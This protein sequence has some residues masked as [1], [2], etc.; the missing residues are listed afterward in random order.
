MLNVLVRS[1]NTCSYR[2]R[3]DHLPCSLYINEK[4]NLETQFFPLFSKLVSAVLPFSRSILKAIK[5]YMCEMAVDMYFITCKGHNLIGTAS[6]N[7]PV[8]VQEA[9]YCAGMSKIQFTVNL[10]F[11]D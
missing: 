4:S 8:N 10:G 5:E 7:R 11:N 2:I 9:N 3:T 6:V 1:V